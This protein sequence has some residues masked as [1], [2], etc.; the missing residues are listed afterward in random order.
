MLLLKKDF[1]YTWNRFFPSNGMLSAAAFIIAVVTGFILSVP[2]DPYKAKESIQIIMISNPSASF[3]RSAHYWSSQ[4]FLI[5]TIIHFFEYFLNSGEKNIKKGVWFRLVT[6]IPVTFF[7]MLSGFILKADNEGIMANEILRGIIS[8]VPFIGI[9][10]EN[11][12]L[13]IKNSLHVVYIHHAATA[14]I[15]LLIIIIEHTKKIWPTIYSYLYIISVTIIVSFVIPAGLHSDS[16]P[17]V[18]GPWYFVGL[19]EILH[20]MSSPVYIIYIMIFLLLSLILMRF[21]ENKIYKYIKYFIILNSVIYFIAFIA[22]WFFRGENWKF[23][24]PGMN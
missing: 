15:Y 8:M 6:A 24:I 5:F 3:I 14:T 1:F 9:Y 20:W 16:D 17:V 7:V 2:Y 19:Q 11:F 21:T 18:K 22:G 13:G 23:I 12:L 10:L 4:F